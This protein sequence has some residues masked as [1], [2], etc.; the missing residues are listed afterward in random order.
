MLNE[1]YDTLIKIFSSL[2]KF[3]SKQEEIF[4]KHVVMFLCP[5]AYEFEGMIELHNL[6]GKYRKEFIEADKRLAAKK[7]SFFKAKNIEKWKLDPQAWKDKD[8]LLKNKNLALLKMLP[9]ETEDTRR[10]Y[11]CF[12]YYA[13]KMRDE[14]MRLLSQKEGEYKTHIE[15]LFKKEND[16]IDD[17]N[18]Y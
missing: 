5:Q 6:I 10:V 8:N 13:N 18:F 7:E 4:N 16:I 14:T 17:V 1:K 12:A 9:Q 2:S 11:T 3:V 15:K